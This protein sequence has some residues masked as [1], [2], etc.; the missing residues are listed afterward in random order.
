MECIGQAIDGGLRKVFPQQG[1]ME[2]AATAILTGTRRVT[3]SGFLA[4]AGFLQR[5]W[6]ALVH[7]RRELWE[8]Y[9]HHTD[10]IS[11]PAEARGGSP[12]RLARRATFSGVV[13]RMEVTDRVPPE[14]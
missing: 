2:Q 9:L 11:V 3:V 10:A 1:K 8:A 7:W 6:H 4:A 14:R 5:V 13:D 12:P